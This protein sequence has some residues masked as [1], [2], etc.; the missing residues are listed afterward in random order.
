M[1]RIIIPALLVLAACSDGPAPGEPV[2][3]VQLFSGYGPPTAFYFA[4]GI[5]VPVLA[6]ESTDPSTGKRSFAY[7]DPIRWAPIP[8][9]LPLDVAPCA[10]DAGDL[11]TRSCPN[12]AGCF[13]IGVV[14]LT[15]AGDWHPAVMTGRNQETD[16]WDGQWSDV[17]GPHPFAGL[18]QC[19][20]TV[21]IGEAGFLK[22]P[23]VY[24]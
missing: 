22:K 19:N 18:P 11:S 8:R 3:S 6:I 5:S 23:S 13:T 16:S 20:V 21:P 7:G 12:D 15:T 2:R 10:A 24:F 1:K 4:P 9:E 17:D 14:S